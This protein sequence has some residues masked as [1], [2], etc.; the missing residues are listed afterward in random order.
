MLIGLGLDRGYFDQPADTLSGG[1][2]TRLGMA[3]LLLR[4]PDLLLLDE[5]TNHLDL[6]ALEWLEGYLKEY[7]GAM[8]IV[9]HDRYFLDA[10]CTDIAE[11]LFG[12]T[13][14]YPGNYSR[15]LAQREG[16]WLP[17]RRLMTC[18]KRRLPGRRPSSPGSS[19]LTGRSP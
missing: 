14:L 19:S 10:V 1:E 5:P 16:A 17:G 2:L 13:E 9:S 3:R 11:L 4:K 6:A 15:Y 8:I 12:V 18:S 7:Q